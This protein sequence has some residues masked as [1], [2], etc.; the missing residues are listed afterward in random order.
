MTVALPGRLATV[1]GVRPERA[2]VAF[3]ELF[4]RAIVRAKA[5]KVQIA[6]DLREPHETRVYEVLKG[7]RPFHGEWLL[8]LRP[9]VVR[10]IVSDL[11]LER[12][13][14]ELRPLATVSDADD[15]ALVAALVRA[16]HEPA[17]AAVESQ[18]DGYL[19]VGEIDRELA[20]LERADQAI[21]H[22]RARLLEARAERGCRLRSRG[23]AR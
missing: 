12:L 19:D 8:L 5:T 10:A 9:P 23:G 18:A 1:D 21:A 16:L 15:H 13:H 17:T 20:L 4:G 2:R 7:M 3:G 14:S 11:A 22:R 6:E